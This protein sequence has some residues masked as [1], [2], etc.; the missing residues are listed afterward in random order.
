M[1]FKVHGWYLAIMTSCCS[2]HF[3]EKIYFYGHID[4]GSNIRV[5]SS[6][7]MAGLK[8]G[9]IEDLDFDSTNKLRLK[10][11]VLKKY[12]QN[13]TLGS[14]IQFT[15]PFLMGDKVLNIIRNEETKITIPKGSF[16]AV[17]Q[18]LDVMDVLSGQKVN[19]LLGRV[20][21]IT[22]NMDEL[23]LASKNIALQVGEKEKIK[24]LMHNLTLASQELKH[25]PQ[26]IKDASVILSNLNQVTKDLPQGGKK[27]IELLDE[28]IT[29]IKAM[30]KNYFLKGHVES[31]KKEEEEKKRSVASEKSP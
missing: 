31:V 6:V 9:K 15:R 30:Q 11:S 25:S 29:T 2:H 13:I 22:K 17:A 16:L 10:F 12:S 5:G 21:S 14:V 1:A 18:K 8:I 28:S 23:V 3:E 24:K 4:S 20:D 7:F 19:E 27:T 26:M